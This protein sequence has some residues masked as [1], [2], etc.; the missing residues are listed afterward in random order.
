MEDES[1]E[2]EIMNYSES[3]KTKLGWVLDTGLRLGK[4][5]VI[6]G[7]AMS[8]V[9]LVLPPLVVISAL[10]FAF[11]VPFGVVFASYTCTQKLMNK[12]LLSPAL[13]PTIC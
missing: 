2:G 11:S 4:N 8:S 13:P 1:M 6:T 10:G 12:L 5:L 3:E 9:P 7:V